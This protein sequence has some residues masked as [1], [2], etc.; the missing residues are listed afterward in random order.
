MSDIEAKVKSLRYGLEVPTAGHACSHHAHG[1]G[2]APLLE[3][4]LV[5]A[6]GVLL[7]PSNARPV[8]TSSCIST[9]SDAAS[10]DMPAAINA[11]STSTGGNSK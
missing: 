8:L 9:M 1:G 6:S 3:L 7:A 2:L 11:R 5:V 10:F 4:P